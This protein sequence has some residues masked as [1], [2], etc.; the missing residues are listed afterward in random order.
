MRVHI[1]QPT[2]FAAPFQRT[3]FKTKK[4]ELV[5][6]TLPY[7]AALIPDGFEVRITDEQVQDWDPEDPC[8]CVFLSVH[9]LNSLRAYEIADTY[10]EK[11]IPVVMGGPHCTFYGEEVL[12]HADAIA[13][14]EGETLIPQVLEDLAKGQCRRRYQAADLHDLVDLPLPRHE[15]LD[16]STLSRFRT[17]AVQTTRGCPY[18]CEFCAERYYLGE[19]YRMRP[20]EEVIEEIR[21]SGGRQV[22]FADS[23]FVG[24]RSRTMEFMERLIPLKIR[25]ST[26]W[27]AHR[28]LDPELMQLAKRS[29]LLHINMGVESIKAET[30]KGMH[31]TTTPAHR[32]EEVVRILR[33]LDI[34]FSFNLI[35]GWDTDRPEDFETTSA[36]L[37]RNRVH[38]AFFNVFSPHK[39]TKIYDRFVAEG[40]LRD[41][42]NMGRWPGVIAEIHPKHFT[43]EE[44]EEGIRGMYRR[45]Y[46][47]PSILRRLPLP[48]S[49]ASAASWFMNLNQ[50]KMFRADDTR[51]NFDGI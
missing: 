6:L 12:E 17:V 22:F 49:K 29:G 40:R 41:E 15:L 39:G 45:F 1:I 2:H 34:S 3:L 32:L 7:L 51:T 37:D 19:P 4:R 5:P 43:A 30:L 9:I 50:R 26:L 24:N 13:V 31:K 46:G 33:R 14:G 27:N 21:H 25:W 18:R 16:P 10:R 8:D 28:V 23:T 36:F 38:V 42:K 20:V 11:G 44:L 48:K 35:F 47:W